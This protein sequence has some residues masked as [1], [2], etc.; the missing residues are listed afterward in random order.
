ME[1]SS[2]IHFGS[3]FKD[4]GRVHWPADLEKI[5]VVLPLWVIHLLASNDPPNIDQQVAITKMRKDAKQELTRRKENRR[6]DLDQATR[7]SQE[8]TDNLRFQKLNHI[9]NIIQSPLRRLPDDLL[10][11]IFSHFHPKTTYCTMHDGL[12]PAPCCLPAPLCQ[13]SKRWNGIAKATPALWQEMNLL[14]LPNGL[15]DSRQGE[16]IER[17]SRLSGALPLALQVEEGRLVESK[18]F[19]D[20][21]EWLLSKWDDCSRMTRL[22][23]RCSQMDDVAE[24]LLGTNISAPE[25]KSLLFT[26]VISDH[27][28]GLRGQVLTNVMNKFPK[29]NHLWMEEDEQSRTQQDLFILPALILTSWFRLTKLYLTYPLLLSQWHFLLKTCPNLTDAWV[30]CVGL[31]D[32]VDFPE[33]TNIIHKSLQ[34]LIISFIQLP[35]DLYLYPYIRDVKFPS[36][37]TFH[38][39]AICAFENDHGSPPTGVFPLL[40]HFLVEFSFGTHFSKSTGMAHIFSLLQTIP[41]ATTVILTMGPNHLI[42][43]F[44]FLQSHANDEKKPLPNIQCLTITLFED[45]F[46]FKTENHLDAFGSALFGI[47]QAWAYQED[48]PSIEIH[49]AQENT[50]A[51]DRELLRKIFGLCS[52]AKIRMSTAKWEEGMYD[53]TLYTLEDTF[54]EGFSF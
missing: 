35:N 17:F 14:C 36:L 24:A 8:Q 43:L 18:T 4:H 39:R 37:H 47:S 42:E 46:W 34:Q 2:T 26:V 38:V 48:E 30:S 15:Q 41:T 45:A 1:L 28:T 49:V 27:D 13:V 40:R 5:V 53:G 3:Q 19:C 20:L 25:L 32:E 22:G 11:H 51:P 16:F 9:Y 23:I 54:R 33:D 6:R 10:Y 52:D 12:W 50:Q 21:V 29:L 31:G 7:K 44:H